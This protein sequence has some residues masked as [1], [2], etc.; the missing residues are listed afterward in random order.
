M[1]GQMSLPILMLPVLSQVVVSIE[2]VIGRTPHPSSAEQMPV[3]VPASAV[4]PPTVESEWM[5]AMPATY[6]LNVRVP[7]TATPA[8]S[9]RIEPPSFGTGPRSALSHPT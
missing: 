9:D 8:A 1:I 5:P 6:V 4:A 3:T 7:L 2:N